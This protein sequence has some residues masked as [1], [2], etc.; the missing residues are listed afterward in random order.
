MFLIFI[1]LVCRALDKH[2]QFDKQQ[3]P[4]DVTFDMT[5]ESKLSPPTLTRHKN[6]HVDRYFRIQQKHSCP[7]YT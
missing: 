6:I 7:T 5:L 2:D 3:I 1:I 4:S